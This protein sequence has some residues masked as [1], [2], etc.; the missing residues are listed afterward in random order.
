[1]SL[2]L[3][4]ESLRSWRNLLEC[5]S[6]DAPA[7]V[8]QSQMLV[9][10]NFIVLTRNCWKN[11][12]GRPWNWS[13]PLADLVSAPSAPS[14][15]L[16]LGPQFSQSYAFWGGGE[17]GKIACWCQWGG[18]AC[19]AGGV[20]GGGACVAGET[21]TAADGTHP[22]GMHSC[23]QFF[24]S[25]WLSR[26]TFM[27]CGDVRRNVSWD[28]EKNVTDVGGA[29]N[30]F[31]R[32]YVRTNWDVM[33]TSLLSFSPPDATLGGTGAALLIG[34]LGCLGF[35]IGAVHDGNDGWVLYSL[36]Q[37]AWNHCP[38]NGSFTLPETESDSDSYGS[39]VLSVILCNVNIHGIVQ[40]SYWV[41]NPSLS[42]RLMDPSPSRAM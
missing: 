13:L 10:G 28:V 8:R 12:D 26:W 3:Y 40:C 6:T 23:D 15:A 32:H 31:V 33:P 18:G 41:S 27:W 1:M 29:I 38:P 37:W 39:R 2:I 19:M 4:R 9:L 17:F 30:V 5:E 42:L 22:T 34:G 36:L 21:A 11:V 35:Y 25:E 14:P 24:Q 7:N 16:H 20:R